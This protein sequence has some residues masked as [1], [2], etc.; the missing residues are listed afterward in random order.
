[1]RALGLFDSRKRL[2]EIKAP[3]MVITGENDTTVPPLRQQVLV[4]G[5]PGARRAVIAGAGHAA[6]VDRPEEFNRQLLGYLQ[7]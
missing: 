4:A 3:T 5:I 7:E 2:G 6:S 1:M